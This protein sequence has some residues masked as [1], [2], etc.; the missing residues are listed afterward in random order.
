MARQNAIIRADHC[1]SAETEHR[2]GN[3]WRQAGHELLEIMRLWQQSQRHERAGNN[4]MADVIRTK[5]LEYAAGT[6]VRSGWVDSPDA[7]SAEYFRIELAGGG[8]CVRI[9]GSL[10]RYN[11]PCDPKLEYQDWGTPWLEFRLLNDMEK[12]A[13]QWFTYQFYWGQ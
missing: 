9:T 3:A 5:C 11:D 7:M 6:S 13:V 4:Q 8:P 2:A 10:D 12:N 1:N